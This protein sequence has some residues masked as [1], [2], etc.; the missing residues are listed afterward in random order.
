M[1]KKT[2]RLAAAFYLAA[3]LFCTAQNDRKVLI[4]ETEDWSTP[5]DAWLLDKYAPDKWTLWT[6]E[7][8]AAKKRSGAR[9]LKTPILRKNHTTPEE[10]AP[11]L[12]TKLT[13]IPNGLYNVFVSN[14]NRPIAYSLDGK[15]WGRWPRTS[16]EQFLGLFKITDGTF[17]MWADDL[18]AANKANM[19]SAY[20]D[21]IK[22]KP[23]DNL[24]ELQELTAFTRPDGTTQLTWMSSAPIPACELLYGINGKMDNIAKEDEDGFRNHEVILPDLKKGYTYTAKVKCDVGFGLTLTGKSITFVAGQRPI[25]GPTVAQRIPLNVEEPT[26]NARTAWP[27]TSGVPFGRGLLAS[28]A[29]A[30]LLGPDGKR[31]IAQLEPMAFWPDGSIK[32]LLCSFLADTTPGKPTTYTLETGTSIPPQPIKPSTKYNTTVPSAAITFGDG[33]TA[34][35][36]EDKSARTISVGP[37]TCEA[38]HEGDFV[39]PDGKPSGFRWRVETT[40]WDTPRCRRY[41]WYVGNAK[42]DVENIA[43]R[44]ITWTDGEPATSPA[45]SDGTPIKNTTALQDFDSHATLTGPDGTKSLERLD[46]FIRL[47]PNRALWMRDFWQ[48]WPRGFKTADGKLQL[49]I[50]PELPKT[51][52]PQHDLNNLDNL[53]QYFYWLGD[54]GTYNFKRGM[55]FET[56]V[57]TMDVEPAANSAAL[58]NWLAEPLFAVAPC[59]Y[60]CA[61]GAFGPLF[62]ARPNVFPDFERSLDTSFANLEKGRLIRGEYGWMNYGDW[63]GERRWNWGN[64]EYDLAFLCA[65]EFARTGRRDF[66]LR[67]EQMARHYTTIDFMAYLWNPKQRERIYEHCVG[68]TGGF[69]K[70]NDPRI[71][72]SKRVIFVSPTIDGSGGHDFSAGSFFYACLTGNRHFLQVAETACRTQAKRFTPNYRITIERA[73]GWTLT[74]ATNAFLFTNDPYYLNCAKIIFEAIKKQ[75]NPETGCMDLPQDQSECD[76]P[77]KKEHRGGKAFATGVMLHGLARYYEITG[78]PDAVTVITRSASWLLDYAW[79]KEN[80]GFRYKTGCP[81]FAKGR[82]ISPIVGEGLAYAGALSKNPRFFTFIKE[83][84]GSVLRS[85]TGTGPSCGKSFTTAFRTLPYMLYWLECAG[86]TQ[87]DAPPPKSLPLINAYIKPDGTAELRLIV[88]NPT[89]LTLA[90]SATVAGRKTAWKAPAGFSASPAF[91]LTKDNA[92]N[93]SLFASLQVGNLTTTTLVRLTP[94]PDSP[95]L[96]G[97]IGFI[98]GKKHF[99]AKALETAGLKPTYLSDPN[100]MDLNGFKAVAFGGDCLA[101]NT[102]ALTPDGAARLIAFLRAGGRVLFFQLNDTFFDNGLLNDSLLLQED[103]GQADAILA[104]EHPLFKDIREIKPCVCYDS[105]AF[106]GPS[107]KFLAKDTNGRPCIIS[108]QEGKGE[109]ILV[110]PSFDREFHTNDDFAQLGIP[111]ETCRLFMRNAVQW[112]QK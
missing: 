109:V 95:K 43:V 101:I 23:V 88:D 75:Q 83:N 110:M 111:K 60:Y 64:N 67:G 18:F 54:N 92:R 56:D 94:V 16:G 99:T 63:F 29:D 50:L 90:C 106:A 86:I 15:N 33:T 107:W 104:P 5:K 108:R 46:G 72:N 25:P 102:P 30:R 52:Y 79:D 48:T 13:G 80:K 27:I 53:F 28:P 77:D 40:V 49:N 21:Y 87:L 58:A 89:K 37:V 12:H 31:V 51:G 6:K 36:V 74:N 1:T 96:G 41:R 2:F 19:G 84:F 112:L 69:I 35:S 100:K 55:E 45:L 10:G 59:E 9:T 38:C 20:Y 105:I 85:T 47:S 42:L 11:P 71:A 78:D 17:E 65:T 4:F 66:L 8:N 98:G 24:P 93:G 26:D 3:V 44:S 57:W 39:F 73:P 7:E 76:C 97:K 103:N 81:K 82:G 14:P 22:L 68:H 70:K 61:T 91:V 62:P 32:W 34:R